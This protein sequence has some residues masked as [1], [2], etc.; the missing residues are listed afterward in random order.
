MQEIR[1]FWLLLL[2]VPFRGRAIPFSF[3]FYSSETINEEASSRNLEHQRA[4]REVKIPLGER[5]LVLDREFSYG[6]M[7]KSLVS[8]GPKFVIR[9]NLDSNT[10]RLFNDEGRRMDWFL[11]LVSA[12]STGAV[13]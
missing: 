13:S 1:G 8:E 9:L 4:F 5:S 12:R 7:L 3:A 11:S 6:D 2:A 10:P